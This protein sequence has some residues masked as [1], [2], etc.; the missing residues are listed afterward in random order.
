MNKLEEMDIRRKSLHKLTNGRLSDKIWNITM[1]GEGL[2]LMDDGDSNASA[3]PP[4]YNYEQNRMRHGLCL[5]E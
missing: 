5:R 4:S 3:K 2:Q 1:K